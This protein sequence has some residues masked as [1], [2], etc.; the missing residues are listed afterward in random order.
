MSARAWITVGWLAMA[1]LAGPAPAG[2][3]AR[4]ARAVAGFD[5]VVKAGVGDLVIRQGERE[6]LVVEAE[7]RLLSRL[8]TEVRQGVLHFDTRG[9]QFVSRHPVRYLLTVRDLKSVDMDGSGDLAASNLRLAGLDLRL[10]G[11]GDT[12]LKGL[13]ADRLDVRITGSAT[14]AVAGRVDRQ[15]V[16]IEG[17]GDYDASR[18]QSDQVQVVIDGAGDVRVR[19]RQRLVARILGS[20]DILYYG[21]PQVEEAVTGA[22]QVRRAG[23]GG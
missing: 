10:A 20:G 16:S 1:L 2:E 7:Q 4:E 11:S 21:D 14:V 5:R 8:S 13:Q 18:V 19:V 22:G 3:L 12:N 9:S 17:A 15:T 23:L 6:S